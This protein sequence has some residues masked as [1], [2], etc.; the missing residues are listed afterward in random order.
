MEFIKPQAQTVFAEKKKHEHER[1]ALWKSIQQ[2]RFSCT[3]ICPLRNVM[4]VVTFVFWSF[5]LRYKWLRG[6]LET[7]GKS[8]YIHLSLLI[9]VESANYFSAGLKA[10][11]LCW[12][13][14][15]AM[16][17]Q[18][19]MPAEWPMFRTDK[20]WMTDGRN[21]IEMDDKK[22]NGAKNESWNIMLKRRSKMS[23]T[24]FVSMTTPAYPRYIVLCRTVGQKVA[25]LEYH[26]KLFSDWFC[27]S[28]VGEGQSWHEDLVCLLSDERRTESGRGRVTLM[29]E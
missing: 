22:S 20:G 23:W 26:Q 21:L 29:D 27:K 13:A 6:Q 15:G 19:G 11:S 28:G 5:F 17:V 7:V 3:D 16:Q 10:L 9:A 18:P 12:V 24:I 4:S 25:Y 2:N 8:I 1:F 14:E